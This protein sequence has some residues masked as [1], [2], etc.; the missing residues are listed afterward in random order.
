MLDVRCFLPLLTALAI[1]GTSLSAAESN[2]VIVTNPPATQPEPVPKTARDAFNAG[3]RKLLEGKLRESEVLLQ[4]SL[5][6]QD[7][8]I[9]SRR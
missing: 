4:S 6:K 7:S 1:A 9:Q 8:G 2:P 3:T 5:A